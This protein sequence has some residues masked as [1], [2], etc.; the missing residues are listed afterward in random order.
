MNYAMGVATDPEFLDTIRQIATDQNTT[1]YLKLKWEGTKLQLLVT[2]EE[3]GK[4]ERL[5]SVIEP[6]YD[7]E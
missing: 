2:E 3:P 6:G 7:S 4:G 5:V 1:R